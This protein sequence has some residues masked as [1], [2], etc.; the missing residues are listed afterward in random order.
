MNF[1]KKSNKVLLYSTVS[2]GLLHSILKQWRACLLLTK[3]DIA[4]SDIFRIRFIC[5]LVVVVS[6]LLVCYENMKDLHTKN[7][8]CGTGFLI[9][10]KENYPNI[11]EIKSECNGIFKKAVIPKI[12]PIKLTLAAK[13]NSHFF[14][15][16]AVT[17]NMAMAI[18]KN[19]SVISN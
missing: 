6:L 11:F 16:N 1:C 19:A 12:I 2:S 10:L 9:C 18:D 3:A 7:V 8:R 13:Y 4:H 5:L 17:P 14:W 15:V